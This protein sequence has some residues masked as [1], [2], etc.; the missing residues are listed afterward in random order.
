[1]RHSYIYIIIT[2][3]NYVHLPLSPVPTVPLLLPLMP[4]LFPTRP[5]LLLCI[6]ILVFGDPVNLIR[7]ASKSVSE[8]LFTRAWAPCRGYTTEKISDTFSHES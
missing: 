5:L 1:M 6:F 8:G 4:L 7:V 2:Y 3:F